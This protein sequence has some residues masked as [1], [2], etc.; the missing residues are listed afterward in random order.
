LRQGIRSHRR[1]GEAESAQNAEAVRTA[2]DRADQETLAE[3]P[4][5]TS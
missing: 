2:D 5:S 3:E 4:G 1:L